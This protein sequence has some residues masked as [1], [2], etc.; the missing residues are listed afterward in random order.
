MSETESQKV[1]DARGRRASRLADA[2]MEW[3]RLADQHSYPRS[4]VEIAEI[5]LK[6]E[7]QLGANAPRRGFRRR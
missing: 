7:Y 3:R 2:F 6:R 1:K 4:L 5:A